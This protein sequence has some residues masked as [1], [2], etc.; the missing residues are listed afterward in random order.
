L[1]DFRRRRLRASLASI[2]R[3]AEPTRS[4]EHRW[5]L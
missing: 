5:G 2:V 4:K 3:W 1:A